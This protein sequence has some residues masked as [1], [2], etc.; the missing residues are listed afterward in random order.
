MQSLFHRNRVILVHISFWCVYMS[1]FFYQISNFRHGRDIDWG[2]ASVF[3]AVQLIISMSI[4]YINYFYLL[5]RL[6]SHK[7][8]WRYLIE[9][10]VPFIILI[11]A[12][13]HLQRFLID[14]YTYQRNHFY[15]TFYIVEVCVITLFIA[16]FIGMLRFAADWFELAAKQ[17]EL[18]NQQLTAELNFLKAQINPHFLFNTLNNLYYLAYTQ[19]ANTTEVISKLSQMMR[20]MIYDTNHQQ[21]P[22]TKEIEYMQNYISLERLRLNDQIPIK[23]EI[24]GNPEGVLIT[25]LIF[26]TFLEN[27]FKHGVSNNFP[28]AWVN[29]HLRLDGKECVY[30]VENSKIP[31]TKPE[32]EEKSGIGLQ[33]VKRRLELSYPDR[34]TLTIE[35]KSDR[36]AIKLNIILS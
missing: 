33:N 9:F 27:A 31:S 1:F 22:L 26:I 13:V 18:E 20:Y 6:L 36:Y 15:S 10:F 30:E 23:F 29:I 28:G 17:R 4:A 25:P 24:Q 2:K 14:G 12:R 34:Y 7:K 16:I 21:V 19:S 11:T 8:L 5:P 32:S 35:D 3:G